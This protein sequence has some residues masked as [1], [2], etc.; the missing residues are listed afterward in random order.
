MMGDWVAVP[1]IVAI[2]EGYRQREKAL[3][4]TSR[5]GKEATRSMD[6]DA[7]TRLYAA[8]SL[9]RYIDH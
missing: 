8:A 7:G 3:V 1:A 4:K 5:P 6:E 9:A 2:V